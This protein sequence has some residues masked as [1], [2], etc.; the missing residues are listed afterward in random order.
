M[1]WWNLAYRTYQGTVCTSTTYI[2]YG[3]YTHHAQQQQIIH[4]KIWPW[5]Y[6][7]L[8]SSVNM[9]TTI[10]VCG[11]P[12]PLFPLLLDS[13]ELSDFVQKMDS[14]S[15]IITTKEGSGEVLAPT[16]LINTKQRCSSNEYRTL[17]SV[18]RSILGSYI[19]KSFHNF[20]LKFARLN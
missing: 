13:Y 8:D 4:L 15:L 16:K 20:N 2:T 7:T 17:S 14:K 6:S 3:T 11:T 5:P 9:N 10:S 18:I 1:F 19:I 12:K